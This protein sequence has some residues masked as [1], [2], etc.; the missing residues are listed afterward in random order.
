MSLLG[1]AADGIDMNAQIDFC[2]SPPIPVAMQAARQHMFTTLASYAF[3]ESVFADDEPLARRCSPLPAARH[4]RR[5]IAVKSQSG[6]NTNQKC[7]AHYNEEHTNPGQARN[8]GAIPG[9]TAAQRRLAVLK[10]SGR[11]RC[12]HPKRA[13]LT[14]AFSDSTSRTVW[15]RADNMCL[16]NLA[17]GGFIVEHEFLLEAFPG[18]GCQLGL[19]P[20]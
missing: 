14:G 4:C 8:A 3:L 12:R 17:Q 7:R 6:G 10:S 2:S 5:K 18:M 16:W 1:S 11:D 15:S 9:V 13:P 19:H 20:G